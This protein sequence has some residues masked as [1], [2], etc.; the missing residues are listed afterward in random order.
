M[1]YFIYYL[2]ILWK[3]YLCFIRFLN[4]WMVHLLSMVHGLVH[5]KIAIRTEACTR[6]YFNFNFLWINM[7]C[8]KMFIECEAW[9]FSRTN[10]A[11]WT[12]D[13]QW[14]FYC[15]HKKL[16]RFTYRIYKVV[17]SYFDMY[18]SN[19]YLIFVIDASLIKDYVWF[20]NIERK[21]GNNC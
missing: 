18:L 9:R 11:Q 19:V 7:L 10:H 15:V 21:A 17:N 6:W 3:K 1:I 2:I 12:S 5:I 8:V 20:Y 16:I 13:A 4:I 14:T